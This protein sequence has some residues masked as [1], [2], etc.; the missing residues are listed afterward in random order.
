MDIRLHEL[1][2][3]PRLLWTN[4]DFVVVALMLPAS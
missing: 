2:D 3:S 1:C 4:P